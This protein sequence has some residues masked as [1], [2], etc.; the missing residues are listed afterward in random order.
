MKECGIEERVFGLDLNLTE[1]EQMIC[2]ILDQILG[3][4]FKDM[5]IGVIDAAY[6]AGQDVMVESMADELDTYISLEKEKIRM[7]P[8][9]MSEHSDPEIEKRFRFLVDKQTEIEEMMQIIFEEDVKLLR[10][11]N[12]IYMKIGKVEAW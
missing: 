9:M 3:E 2:G 10:M 11:K 5:L 4:D 8:L 1:S 7:S 6:E 12:G